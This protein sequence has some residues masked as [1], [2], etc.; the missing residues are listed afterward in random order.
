[1]VKYQKLDEYRVMSLW[2]DEMPEDG[3]VSAHTIIKE[4]DANANINWFNGILCL[5]LRLAP[6]VASNYAMINIKF[7]KNQSSTFKIIYHLIDLNKVVKSDIAMPNDV[8]K[9][10]IPKE[11]TPAFKQVFD[12]LE[13][14]N[15]LPSG[16]LEILGGRYSHIGSSIMAFKIVLKILIKLLEQ[17]EKLID[18]NINSIILDGC[19]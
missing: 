3:I 13:T 6:R 12:E 14:R 10:G 11:Y 5:E 1:M 8:V 18:A 2:V 4:Y 7:T 19:K 9:T 17:N 15:V 16:T